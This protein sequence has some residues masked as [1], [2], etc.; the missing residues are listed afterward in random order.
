M[1]IRSDLD[2]NFDFEIVD[3]FLDHYSMMVESME[4]MI[5]DLSKPNMY[6]RSINELFR[7]FH[8]IK[9]ASGYLQIMSMNKL[10]AFVEDELEALRKKETPVNQETIDWL[11]EVSDMFATWQDDLKLDN[12][13]S[14]INFSLFNTPDLDKKQ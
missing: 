1:G 4:V 13:L 10:A 7:V 3:E 12:E 2:A 6:V 11:L 5:I 9:S 8:N 14:K